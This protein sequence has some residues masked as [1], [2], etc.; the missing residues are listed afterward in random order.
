MDEIQIFKELDKNVNE[1]N[2]IEHDISMIEAGIYQKSLE[3]VKS[4]KLNSVRE[5]FEKQAKTYNQKTSKH[6]KKIKLITEEYEKQMEK[7]IERYNR[8]YIKACENI[9]FARNKQKIAVANMVTVKARSREDN[10]NS[11]ATEQS[12]QMMISCAQK[13]V[14][15]SVIIEEC[16]ARIQWCK[17]ESIGNMDMLFLN[18]WNQMDIYKKNP[19]I[20][21]RRSLTNIIFGKSRYEKLLKD[22]DSEVLK[23]IK[24]KVD[25]KSAELDMLSIG[26]SEQM[27]DVKKQ[28]NAVFDEMMATNVS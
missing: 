5:Y 19:I 1:L 15:Y 3:Q 2:L 7:L 4:E 17:E 23:G 14:N 25:Q 13:K 21:L 12:K 9:Q 18:T 22:Y 10:E 24:S 8:I 11:E 27:N 28:I 16:E 26:I 6:E 20:N